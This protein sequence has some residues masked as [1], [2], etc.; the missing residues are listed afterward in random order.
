MVKQ[1]DGA[2]DPVD[3]GNP[4]LAR[5]DRTV[6]QHAAAS[7]H[8]GR[9]QGDQVRHHRLN[10]VAHEHFAGTKPFD[11][12][13]HG[14]PADLAARQAWRGRLTD[15]LPRRF[16]RWAAGL[17]LL[18]WS[19][20]EFQRHV[21]VVSERGDN[22]GDRFSISSWLAPQAACRTQPVQT[23]ID[24]AKQLALDAAQEQ[25][26]VVAQPPAH[27]AD[28][29]HLDRFF[30]TRWAHRLEETSLQ[31]RTAEVLMRVARLSAVINI[32]C[33][34]EQRV[35]QE[36]RA[37]QKTLGTVGHVHEFGRSAR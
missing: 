11:I 25:V 16:L 3:A 27:S 18:R 17:R 24:G 31:L 30:A 36:V 32:G 15:E 33:Q 35:Q 29:Q 9:S 12:V 28:P 23:Q 2:N 14:D 20:G 5:D 22:R 10:G 4:H 1:L 13:R 6:D 8:N 26:V 19:R 21:R 34:F 37:I 7:F